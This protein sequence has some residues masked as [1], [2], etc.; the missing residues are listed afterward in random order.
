LNK[1]NIIK[2]NYFTTRVFK[3]TTYNVIAFYYL[4]KKKTNSQMSIKFNV[5]P[6][7]KKFELTLYQKYN[8]Q[9]GGEFLHK[10]KGSKNKLGLRRLEI[11]D[12]KNGRHIINTALN[13]INLRKTFSVSDDIYNRIEKNIVLLKAIDT[14][15]E[16]GKIALENIKDY[17]IDAL[18]SIKTSRNQIQIMF[19]DFVSLDEQNL[20]IKRFNEVLNRQRERYFSLFMTNF[21]DNNRKRISF[22]FAYSLINNIYYSEI[23]KQV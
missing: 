7:N 16:E 14:G 19:P 10:I 9:I 13:H 2:I 18:I 3:D 8:W 23:C 5:Y 6:E 17:G 11:D 21:R 20:I 12:I 15:T 22:N 4:K 1:F